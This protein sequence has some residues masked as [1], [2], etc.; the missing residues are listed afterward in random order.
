MFILSLK[1][2]NHESYIS[3]RDRGKV[4]GAKVKTRKNVE[5]K[6]YNARDRAGYSATL[7]AAGLAALNPRAS[8]NGALLLDVSRRARGGAR[9]CV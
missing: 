3:R 6:R 1:V 9:L 5:K 8:G 7:D 2:P 4:R